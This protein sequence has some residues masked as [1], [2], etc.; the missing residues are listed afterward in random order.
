MDTNSSGSEQTTYYPSFVEMT[1]Q[2]TVTQSW[3]SC[4]HDDVQLFRFF[5]IGY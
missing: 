3:I 1:A 5:T 4:S 2:R